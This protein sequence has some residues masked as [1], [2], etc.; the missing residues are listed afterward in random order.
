MATLG[1][2]GEYVMYAA[3]KGAVESL[4]LGLAR[5]LAQDG[6]RSN[7]V[8]PTFVETPMADRL[9]AGA[10]QEK[11]DSYRLADA[12]GFI[13]MQRYLIGDTDD[14]RQRMREEILSTT[15]ADLRNFADAMTDVAA[16]GRVVVLGSEAAI[17]AANAERPGLLTASRIV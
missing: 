6:I 2:A 4:S 10:S 12:K 17:E 16:R 9:L 7:V 13:S 3:S 5:E 15:I 14:A 8:S 11:I 1:G